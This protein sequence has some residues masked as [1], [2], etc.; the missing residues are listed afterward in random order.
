MLNRIGGSTHCCLFPH[1][2][3][4][5][6]SLPYLRLTVGVCGRFLLWSWECPILSLFSSLLL[7][8][9]GCGFVKCFFWEYW[10]YNV[11]PIILATWHITLTDL[12]VL[13]QT[14]IP[15]MSLAGSLHKSFWV[16]SWIQCE[17]N[18]WETF[19]LILI[20]N[21]VLHFV[22]SCDTL[23]DFDTR[24]NAGLWKWPQSVPSFISLYDL[25][26]FWCQFFECVI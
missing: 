4:N 12:G 16:C 21:I 26:T 20:R 9:N 11:F 7:W 22:S 19:V 3:A 14:Y 18:L 25:V 17:C 8:G 2:R 15:G 23:S 5:V 10:H 1:L 6:V 13:S 24:L